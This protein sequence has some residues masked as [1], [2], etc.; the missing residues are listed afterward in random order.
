M[1]T[2]LLPPK[3]QGGT[4]PAFPWRNRPPTPRKLMDRRRFRTGHRGS[5]G[6]N[7]PFPLPPPHFGVFCLSRGMWG[8]C[9][10][11]CCGAGGGGGG[12]GGGREGVLGLGFRAGI[13]GRGFSAQ[14]FLG[15][16]LVV[17][18][19]ALVVEG[20]LGLGGICGPKNLKP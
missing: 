4:P 13:S 20:G 16:S 10:F 1:K 6:K 3:T 15:V 11:F 8:F 19:I 5:C 2:S 7:P 18:A 9:F 12:G 17:P 14:S